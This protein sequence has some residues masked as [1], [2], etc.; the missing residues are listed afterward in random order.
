MDSRYVN[1]VIEIAKQIPD[2]WE[3]SMSLLLTPWAEG[4]GGSVAMTL[5]G[6]GRAIW[7]FLLL[8]SVSNAEGTLFIKSYIFTCL[9]GKCKV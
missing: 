7:G 8:A 2:K 3:T 5:K 6:G 4:C 1:P 9:Q